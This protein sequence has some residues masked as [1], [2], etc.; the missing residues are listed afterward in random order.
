MSHLPE[1][2]NEWPSD[3]YEL[4]CVDKST[5]KK[6]LKK[7]YTKL[8]RIYNPNHSPEHFRKIREAY[9]EILEEQKVAAYF[10]QISEEVPDNTEEIETVSV[11]KETWYSQSLDIWQEAIAGNVEEALLKFQEAHNRDPDPDTTLKLYWLMKLTKRSSS[12][13]ILCLEKSIQ[14]S[15]DSRVLQAY[16]RELENEE[17]RA[18]EDDYLNFILNVA[19]SDIALFRQFVLKRWVGFYKN[20]NFALIRRDVEEVREHFSLASEDQWALLLL[21]VHKFI[22]FADGEEVVSML[23]QYH[24]ELESIPVSSGG[25]FDA[26]MD[27]YEYLRAVRKV[28]RKV[29]IDEL[30]KEWKKIIS[31]FWVGNEALYRENLRSIMIDWSLNPL[32]ALSSLDNV[33]YN[34]RTII[35][36]QIKRI[37]YTFSLSQGPYIFISDAETVGE[38]CRYFLQGKE[39]LRYPLQR[40]N[41]LKFCLNEDVA[42]DTLYDY[43][44][45]H[46]LIEYRWAAEIIEDLHQAVFMCHKSLMSYLTDDEIEEIS[47]SQ[48][49]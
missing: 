21:F 22:S 41:L 2:L 4:L 33:P 25:E 32:D 37:V 28:V 29:E 1:N 18:L 42:P 17:S 31:D 44:V 47:R 6:T 35:F 38:K 7:I 39:G 12:E 24:S 5:D 27:H 14:I 11:E 15:A 9:D 48:A 34:M 16:F 36:T 40:E 46:Q 8:I 13:L 49:S 3:P 23:K 19:G 45:E 26:A 43:I 20:K 30:P 10:A